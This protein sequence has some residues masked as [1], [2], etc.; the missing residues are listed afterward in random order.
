MRRRIF[1]RSSIFSGFLLTTGPFSSNKNE[2]S[3]IKISLNTYS[4]N[5]QLREGQTD[6]FQLLDFCKQYG[7]DAIDPTGYYFPGYPDAPP[8]E[9]IYE[10]KR[11]AFLKGVEISG[12]GIRNDFANADKTKLQQDLSL[13]ESWCEVASKLGAPLLRVFPGR[14]I[15]DGRDKDAVIEQLIIELGKAC[16]IGEKYGIMMALQNHNELLLS[17][18]EII[19]VLGGV[20]SD[21]LGLHLDIGSLA[22]QDPY[23]E[24]E[25][26]ISY[27]ITWQF[28]ELVWVDGVKTPVNYKKL[29][30]IIKSS[31]YSGY[32][33]LETLNADPRINIPKMIEQV[34]NQF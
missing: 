5:R 6:L 1:F 33:P 26:L 24:I 32:L 31:G 30:S 29:M 20:N 7:F 34:R 13:I 3:G 12:T 2:N 22:H 10:F 27:A 21:W 15:K 4:F 11:K 18:D 17:S 16:K 19:R 23:Y 25:K 14:E 9:Y 28:K 8:D